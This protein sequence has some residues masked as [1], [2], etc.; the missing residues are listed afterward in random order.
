LDSAGKQETEGRG[1]T[2]R[3][4]RAEKDENKKKGKGRA[5]MGKERREGP[6]NARGASKSTKKRGGKEMN[7][8]ILPC[9]TRRNR[10]TRVPKG[11]PADVFQ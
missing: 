1:K 5:K 11:T 7:G 8:D 4:E 3:R 10:G 9:N 2:M 6:T